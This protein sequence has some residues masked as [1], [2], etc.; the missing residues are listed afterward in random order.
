MAAHP[1][2]AA[3]LI[4]CSGNSSRIPAHDGQRD[5]A[6]IMGSTASLPPPARVS[7]GLTVL[8]RREHYKALNSVHVVAY[9]MLR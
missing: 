6:P 9:S 8:A 2:E 7:N 1:A 3:A 5:A 4:G